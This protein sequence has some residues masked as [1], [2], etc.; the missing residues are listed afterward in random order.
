MNRDDYMKVLFNDLTPIQTELK[1]EMQQAFLRVYDRGWYI[2]GTEKEIFEKQFA[3][4][5]NVGCCI[6]VG[7]G[8]E[9]IRLILQGMGIHVGD[10]VIV[11]ATT[12]IATALAVTYVGAKPV[13]VEV[14]LET[15]TIDCDKIE[16]KIT[17]R[18]KAIIAVH[19]Y[20]QT[21]DMDRI[22]TIARKYGVK[23]IEDAAQAHGALYKG[24]RVGSLGDAA[25]FSFYPGKN[26]GALGDAGAV[27]TNDIQ[28]A[29]KVRMLSNYGSDR[30]YHHIYQGTNSRLDELQAAFLRVKLPKLDGWNAWRRKVA[31]RYENEICNPEVTHPK[32]A[33]YAEPVWHVYAV[34]T[35]HRNCL[36]KWLNDAGIETNI[37]YPIP[38]HRQ[39][40]YEE[41]RIEMGMLP[42]AEKIAEEEL[43]I[44][45]FYGITNDQVSYV[46]ERINAWNP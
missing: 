5:C 37:H 19:L 35:K 39:K 33:E 41:L 11:P 44:P 30:K 25:A 27:V 45:I 21:C 46:I 12:F 29:D 13:F 43:S 18:T 15:Y 38:M 6:G 3:S 7:N 31:V 24:H 10:E 20:G 17:D 36:K 4:Y 2:G 42:V 16:E 8:L 1:E 40:A 9:A 14:D 34:R 23:V 32:V 22:N 26:L 28:L